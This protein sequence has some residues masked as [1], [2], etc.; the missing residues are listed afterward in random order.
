MYIETGSHMARDGPISPTYT[1]GGFKITTLLT[2]Y[3][4]YRYVTQCPV[5][6]LKLQVNY[7]S[8]DRG[9]LHEKL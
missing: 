3:Q 7:S 8:Q 2:K 5:F 1:S 6:S 4:N 9:E